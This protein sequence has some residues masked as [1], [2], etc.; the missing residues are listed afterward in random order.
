MNKMLGI[1]AQYA[2]SLGF[3]LASQRMAQALLLPMGEA[4]SPINAIT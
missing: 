2:F 4:E 3:R 1:A